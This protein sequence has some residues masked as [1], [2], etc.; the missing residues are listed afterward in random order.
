MIKSATNTIQKKFRS[1]PPKQ[2]TVTYVSKG[3]DLGFGNTNRYTCD[4]HQVDMICCDGRGSKYLIVA[5]K[6]GSRKRYVGFDYNL[7]NG[8]CKYF[9]YDMSEKEIRQMTA[10]MEILVENKW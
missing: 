9:D 1:A 8:Q 5:R 3:Y 7:K 4:G 6:P 10:P 2:E